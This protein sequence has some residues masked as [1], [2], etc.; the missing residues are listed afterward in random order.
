MLVAAAL[1]AFAAPAFANVNMDLASAAAA[2]DMSSVTTALQLGANP[3][4]RDKTGHTPLEWAARNGHARVASYLLAHGAA[5]DQV[6]GEGYT[7]L[8]WAAREG[9]FD[10]VAVLVDAGANPLMRDGQGRDALAL[11]HATR[12]WRSENML[13]RY[14]H[15]ETVG[16]APKAK[17]PNPVLGG[18]PVAAAAKPVAVAARPTPAPT[19]VAPAA[20]NPIVKA[21]ALKK[22]AEAG[23]RANSTLDDYVRA[24]ALNPAALTDPDVPLGKELVT[25]YANVARTQ[26]LAACRTD[27]VKV[28]SLLGA[29]ADSRFGQNIADVDAALKEAGL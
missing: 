15:G 4:A 6:D 2:G 5:M 10:T 16:V 17:R 22:I 20:S 18:V 9:R 12:D 27:L 3:N 13:T 21:M 25:L 28:K 23:G 26:D 14:L 19:P 7:A 8:M 24:N 11:A 1:A 29:R